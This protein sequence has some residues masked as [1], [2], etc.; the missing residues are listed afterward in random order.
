MKTLGLAL[1]LAL[2]GA[3]AG[4]FG[5]SAGHDFDPNEFPEWCPPG[6]VCVTVEEYETHWDVCPV[7]EFIPTP[8]DDNGSGGDPTLTP[9]DDNKCNRGIGNLEE[10]CDPGNSFGQGK[11]EGRSAGEDRHES[12]GPPGNQHGSDNHKGGGKK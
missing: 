2:A 6:Y 4:V 10:G 11:G 7:V 1:A 9:P 5:V 12:E 8:T 3:V